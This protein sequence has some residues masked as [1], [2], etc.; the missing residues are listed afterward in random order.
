MKSTI[1]FW[2]SALLL[3]LTIDTV[4]LGHNLLNAAN[5][6]TVSITIPVNNV[7]YTGPA[8]IYMEAIAGDADGTINKV[9]FYNGTTL[10]KTEYISPYTHTWNNVQIGNYILT[11]KAY[12]NSC[13]GRWLCAGGRIPSADNRC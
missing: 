10:L 13:N 11:A 4:A 2:Y 12:D 8:T 3:L 6:P 7:K 5:A 9:E 1:L